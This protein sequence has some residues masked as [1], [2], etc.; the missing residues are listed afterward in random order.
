M[1][2]AC[3]SPSRTRRAFTLIELLVVIAIIGLLIG[4]LL[5]AVQKVREA[6]NRISCTNHLH[7]FGLAVHNHVTAM[8]C[9]PTAGYGY[10]FPTPPIDETAAGVYVYPPSFGVG[11]S[12]LNGEGPKR[13]LAGWG[14]QLL[15]FLEQENLYNGSAQPILPTPQ[16]GI[17][18]AQAAVMSAQGKMFQCPSL[19]KLRVFAVPGSQIQKN[20]Q[21]GVPYS[22][23]QQAAAFQ[24]DYAANGGC[25]TQ[26]DPYNGAFMPYPG[27]GTVLRPTL[28][29][30]ADFKD[31]Q[32][33]TV[34]I[35]EKLFNRRLAAV[36]QPDDFFG[37]AAGWYY[38]TIRF[39]T[40]QG[41]PVSPQP[42]YSNSAFVNNQGRFGSPHISSTLFAFGDGS[43]RAVRFTVDPNVFARLCHINDGLV[44]NESDYQ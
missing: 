33:N 9:L 4:L 11:V 5:P 12:A 44:V 43:V 10:S 3:F 17:D 23:L 35:G 8:D 30:W 27:L 39:G 36:Q 22:T 15:P 25:P 26:T 41:V 28:R 7:Q 42:D 18:A 32:S 2:R 31:G 19:A 24:T 38:S 20:N 13:Q 6:A 1:P 14:Y 34:L 29:T 16:P 40:Y 37:Y 21:F